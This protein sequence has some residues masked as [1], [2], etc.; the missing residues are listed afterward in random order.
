MSTKLAVKM[1]CYEWPKQNLTAFSFIRTTGTAIANSDHW[2]QITEA[3]FPVY[4]IYIFLKENKAI[5]LV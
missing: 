5:N 2:L 4:S 3:R 1:K